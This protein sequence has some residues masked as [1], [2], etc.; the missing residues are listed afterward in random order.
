MLEGSAQLIAELTRSNLIHGI[1][2]GTTIYSCTCTKFVIAVRVGAIVPTGK[3][4][5]GTV[6]AR[7]VTDVVAV[8]NLG[9]V[10][11]PTGNT[12]TL[13]ASLYCS[14]VIAVDEGVGGSAAVVTTVHT[15]SISTCRCDI[16]LV[17]AI[18]NQDGTTAL[19]TAEDTGTTGR[20]AYRAFCDDVSNHRTT[21]GTAN[22]TL[23][24]RI[25]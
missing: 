4:S 20:A 12:C 15:T 10:A 1:V 24:L 14:C 2:V 25:C 3:T 7:H 9:I 16:G 5:V 17:A 21:R 11:Q 19:R 8:R 22:Q 23:E 13:F 6:Y 18:L